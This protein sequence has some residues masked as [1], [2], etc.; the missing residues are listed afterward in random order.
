MFL[1][2]WRIKILYLIGRGSKSFIKGEFCEVYG[3]EQMNVEKWRGD[4]GCLK[5]GDYKS[6][7]EE[8]GIRVKDKRSYRLKNSLGRVLED[9][10]CQMGKMFRLK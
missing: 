10:W 9:F 4:E 5:R 8:M 3:E 1:V 7:G 2:S 6:N